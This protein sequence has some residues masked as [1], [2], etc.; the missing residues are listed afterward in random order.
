MY[1]TAPGLYLLA[2]ASWEGEVPEGITKVYRFDTAVSAVI[3]R[4]FMDDTDADRAAIQ[5]VINQIMMYP[6]AE[7]TGKL[8]TTDW[9]QAPT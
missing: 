5:P 9:S 4:A 2:P 7:Y 1:G 8:Q 6:L 3:P